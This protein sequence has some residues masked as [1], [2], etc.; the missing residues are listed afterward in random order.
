MGCI[1]DDYYIAS[2]IMATAR[3]SSQDMHH[4]PRAEAERKLG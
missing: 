4:G 1:G 2:Y 3:E